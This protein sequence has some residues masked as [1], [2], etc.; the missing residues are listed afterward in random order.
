L[1]THPFFRTRKVRKSHELP[2]KIPSK[3]NNS[4]T[5][6]I[7]ELPSSNDE[8]YEN[9]IEPEQLFDDSLASSMDSPLHYDLLNYMKYL[10]IHTRDVASKYLKKSSARRNRFHERFIEKYRGKNIPCVSDWKVLEKTENN[11]ISTTPLNDR[12]PHRVVHPELNISTEP[13]RKEKQ[14]ALMKCAVNPFL[15]KPLSEPIVL[16]LE[17][18]FSMTQTE[19]EA[20]ITPSIPK[21]TTTTPTTTGKTSIVINLDRL[22]HSYWTKCLQYLPDLHKLLQRSAATKISN[23]KKI[24]QLCRREVKRVEKNSVLRKTKE[25]PLRAKRAMKEVLVFWKKNEKEER[26]L[27][28][29]AEKE[30]AEQRKAEE[31]LREAKRQ[32]RKLNFLITQT[33]LYSHFIGKKI[34]KVK[35]LVEGDE[36]DGMAT[37]APPPCSMDETKEI[38]FDNEDDEALAQRAAYSAQ[39]A[40]LAQKAQTERFDQDARK[41]RLEARN[42]DMAAAVDTMDFKTTSIDGME[43]I[44]Q[45]KMLTCTLKSYQV[46]GLNWLANLY[47]QGINGILADEMGLGKTVQSISLMAYLAEQH[48]IWG[49]FLVITPVSTLHNW[50]QEIAKFAPDLRALP[51]WGNQKDRKTLR[52]FWSQKKLYSRD[53][54]F[55][56][57]ITSYQLVV[58][59]E[60]HFR[61]IKWQYMVLDEAQAIKSSSSERWKTLLGFHCRNRLLLTGTPIQNSMQELWAL[62]HFIMPT[63]FDSHEEFAEWFSKDIESHAENRGT[64]NQHQLRRLHMILK[65][66][67]LRRVKKDVE[68]ELGD[69]IE[70]DVRC[71]LRPKQR[72]LYQGLKSKISI[73]DLM[74]K[75]TALGDNNESM[76]SLMN[77]MM[78]FRKVCNHPQLFERPEVIAP[79]QMFDPDTSIYH[80]RKENGD[81]LSIPF[82]ARGALKFII[83]KLVY[84]DGMSLSDAAT[85]TAT[86]PH[87][88]H[89]I[90]NVTIT[91]NFNIWS[92]QH[93]SES[94]FHSESSSCKFHY[95]LF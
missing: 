37:T 14:D 39:K 25:V 85:T 62:L 54:P 76:D 91:E 45:P 23:C 2:R 1:E 22:R 77:V 94:F 66:F 90:G 61:R 19:P 47:E 17:N 32:G 75:V 86:I 60:Q 5:G 26:E 41:R 55:H 52:K 51:Y 80:H 6:E 89:N 33:E 65:P 59:D 20:V 44:E 69:K 48:N 71:E 82:S 68:N 72:K 18:S 53:A 64:L 88:T 15:Q 30:A 63:I 81:L 46:K 79:F 12:R 83:P 3:T 27:R 67:M 70:I 78:Q 73:A 74:Q 24:A 4:V 28:K 29:K 36:L 50:Q 43:E 35:G 56:V 58:T 9:D 11:L 10:R 8:M 21:A 40:M 31:D 16:E 49:P 84:R 38:D 92:C 13:K 95:L 87:I 57:L 7:A 42:E 34:E 93:I